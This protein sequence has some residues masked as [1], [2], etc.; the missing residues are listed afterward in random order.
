MHILEDPKSHKLIYK[1]IEV[2]VLDYDEKT[3]FYLVHKTNRMGLV[4]DEEGRCILNGGV[5]DKGGLW[6]SYN[7]MGRS[8]PVQFLCIPRLYFAHLFDKK[9]L[10][11]CVPF[12]DCS[13]M[14]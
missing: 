1:W 7:W 8:C 9:Q 5:T 13:L 14:D 10:K 12:G 11:I 2:G 3:K 6:F 4:R